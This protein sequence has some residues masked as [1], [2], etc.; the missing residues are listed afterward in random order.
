[1]AIC[2]FVGRGYLQKFKLDVRGEETFLMSAESVKDF[3][4]QEMIIPEWI[5]R[6]KKYVMQVQADLI[7]DR[8]MVIMIESQIFFTYTKP[9]RQICVLVSS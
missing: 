4:G 2:Y 8:E 3:Q 1:M 6:V 7:Q 9:S 5:G